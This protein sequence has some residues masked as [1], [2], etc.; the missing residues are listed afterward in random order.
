MPVQW[1]N[2]PEP[3]TSA[4]SPGTIV[5]GTVRARRRGP[6]A[7]VA[8]RRAR[9]RGSSRCDGDLDEAVAGQSVTLTLAD[10]IDVSRGDVHRG[11]RRRRP[12]SP[13]SSRRT[14]CGWTTTPM[15][16]GRPYLLKIGTQT[17][18]GDD[19]AAQVQGQRQHARAPRR[20][21]RSSSTRS[22]CAT[23]EPRPADRRS[24]RTPTTA[25]PAAS[26]SST[27]SPT[28]PS[29]PGMLHFALRRSHN[30]HWQDVD[31]DK[32]RARRAEGPDGRACVWFTGLSGAGK[33]TIAN[34]VETKLHALGP[35]HLPA[36]RRQRPPRPQQG[37]RLHRR[38]PG[39][40]HPPRRRG[41]AR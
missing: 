13:T 22:A 37:P 32:A 39:R 28:T 1:V 20:D 29:A 34:L 27:G 33:S 6:R 21:A 38:R 7:A 4:A 40:E 25:T 8:A 35:P 14:S 9:S 19:R 16:P 12:R 30:V 5:G 26:S 24:T 23:L 3:R 15:L 31:V 36:R 18:D 41:R 2:R 17:V 10:E 11:R